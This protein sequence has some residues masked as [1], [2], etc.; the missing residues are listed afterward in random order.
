MHALAFTVS[1]LTTSAMFAM[2]FKWMPDAKVD[3]QD[4]ILGAVGTAA[5]FEIGKFVISFYIGKQGLNFDLRR[6]SASI[7]I[8]LIWVYY[9]AQIFVSAQSLPMLAQSKGIPEANAG[10]D[11]FAP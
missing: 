11:N 2:I 5:L 10:A 7:V 6:I 8:V 4:V 1:F 9:S 3:W